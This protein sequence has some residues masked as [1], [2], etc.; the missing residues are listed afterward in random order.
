MENYLTPQGL[1]K[2]KEDLDYLKNVKRKEIAKKLKKSIAYGDLSENSEYQEAKES[3]SF[4]EG[5]ILE[6]EEV[7][8]TAVIVSKKNNKSSTAQLGS[9]ILIS[10]NGNKEKIELVGSIESNPIEG[11]ISI[12]SPLGRALL[13]KNEGIFIE[14]NVPNGKSK[15]KILKID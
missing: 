10:N 3:Q 14:I 1:K 13:D 5:Q 8:R 6:L 11:K 7:V 2:A 15:Y 12:E 9:I 4:L